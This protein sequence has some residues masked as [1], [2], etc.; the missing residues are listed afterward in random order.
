MSTARHP[1]PLFERLDLRD[2]RGVFADRTEAGRALA[3]FLLEHPEELA[4]SPG[5]QEGRGPASGADS[6]SPLVLAIPAGGVPVG[7]AVARALGWR[8]DLHLVR[9]LPLPDNSEAGFGALTLDGELLLDQE[10]VAG[11]GLS[12]S[13]IDRQRRKVAADLEERNAIFREGRPPPEVTGRRII[14]TDDGLAS[15]ATMLLALR[16][17]RRRGASLMVVAVPT[18]PRF[19]LA[20]V[21]E[22]ADAVFCL[23]VRAG[24]TFAVADAYRLWRDLD[25]AEI[26]ELLKEQRAR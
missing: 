19:T 1:G 25:R 14:L 8:L 7:I 20:R 11:L 10:F 15:G 21:R 18:A 9:K 6:I 13:D 4:L 3:A 24:P 16:S 12:Q 23:N 2:R 17:L 22:A 5:G 26:V